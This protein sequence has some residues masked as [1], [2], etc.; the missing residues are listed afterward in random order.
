M[1]RV[2]TITTSDLRR[3]YDKVLELDGVLDTKTLL[4]LKSEEFDNKVFYE[5]NKDA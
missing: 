2:K 1:L 4:I 5:D 3:F